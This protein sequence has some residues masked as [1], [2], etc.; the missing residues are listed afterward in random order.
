[1]QSSHLHTH[2]GAALFGVDL[3][4]SDSAIHDPQ[5]S[6]A[7]VENALD[8]RCTEV[9]HD[10]RLLDI[11][12]SLV[13]PEG[14]AVVTDSAE[15]RGP[16]NQGVGGVAVTLISRDD[17]V[18][19]DRVLTVR[20]ACTEASVTTTDELVHALVRVADLARIQVRGRDRFRTVD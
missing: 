14:K 16:L 6:G 2:D 15:L 19:V 5:R 17:D 9:D 13:F 7:I 1:D 8:T 3:E 20:T 12:V 18:A 10:R 4:D 11:G